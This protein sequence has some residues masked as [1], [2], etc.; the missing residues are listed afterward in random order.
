MLFVLARAGLIFLTGHIV[1]V[2]LAREQRVGR[3]VRR[4]QKRRAA[5]R[6]LA[7]DGMNERAHAL[8][9]PRCDIEQRG[10]RRARHVDVRVRG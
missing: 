7:D 6:H 1:F 5:L 3:V 8:G 4:V 10:R 2:S 9:V